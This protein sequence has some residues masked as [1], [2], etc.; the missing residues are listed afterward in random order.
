MVMKALPG[1]ILFGRDND[2]DD[3]FM[4]AVVEV[5]TDVYALATAPWIWDTDSLAY[6]KEQQASISLNADDLTVSMADVEK[7]LNDQYYLRSK[8]YYDV[9]DNIEY[10]CFN[11]DIDANETDTD[12]FCWKFVWTAG[13][14]SG[15]ICTDKEGPRQGAVDSA[16]SGLAWN[17]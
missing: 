14:V 11:T 17:I 15:F 1:K 4:L 9:N 12:W 7:L 13:T 6:A 16:P 3:A 2:A 5:A 10:L 8:K